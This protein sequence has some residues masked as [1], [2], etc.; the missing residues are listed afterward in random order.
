MTESLSFGTLREILVDGFRQLPDHRRGQNTQYTMCDAALAAFSVF[1]MQCPSFLSYQRDMQRHKGCNNAASLFG[2]T[3][4]PS[5]QQMRNLLDP[6]APQHLGA[7]FWAILDRLMEDASVASAFD[8]DGGW[9]C[10]LDGTQYFSSNTLHCPQ[11]T[12]TEYDETTRYAHSA[13]IPVLVKPGRKEVLALEPE[14]IV[15]QDGTEKQD[16]E[17]NAAHRW[18]KRNAN[19]FAERQVTILADDLHCNQPFCELLLGHDLNFILTCK[20]NSHPTLY[21][22]VHLLDTFG[23]VSTCEDRVWNGK[24]YERWT[25]RFA[26]HVPLREPPEA[27]HVNWCEITITSEATGDTLYHSAFAT[28]H[29]VREESVRSTVAAGRARWKV[30]NEG[31]NVLKRHGYYL[32]H[33]YG[34]GDQHLSTVIVM[35]ILLAF[36]CHTV[37]R[38]CDRSYQRLRDELGTRQTFFNDLQALT[39]YIFFRSWDHLT[40]FMISGLDMAPG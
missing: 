28:N 37:L 2:I 39:R 23:A 10:S 15:P 20:P 27:L 11:C 7:P 9:L 36:L 30:E 1:F 35:L 21:E 8:V 13:L 3:Q 31:Y 18:V 25:Y 33:N 40:A 6:V 14:F 19:H 12:V 17:R 4:I 5:D 29:A 22:E 26:D 24:A 34:H 16:C 32:E 38:L